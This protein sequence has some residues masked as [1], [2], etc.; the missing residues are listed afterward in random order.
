M[1]FLKINNY[2][3]N[4]S[5]FSEKI[6]FNN[7]NNISKHIKYEKQYINKS[8]TVTNSNTMVFFKNVFS[9]HSSCT[10]IFLKNTSYSG[11][12]LKMLSGLNNV[13]KLFFFNFFKK[14]KFLELKF[15]SYNI[16]FNFSKSN[17]FFFDLNYIFKN[18]I[19]LNESIFS[20][21]IVKL[22]KRLKKKSKSK[23]DFELK[24]LHKNKRYSHTIK[25][26]NLYSNNFNYYKF[27]ERILST[28]FA[29]LFEQKNSDL[30]KKKIYTY[31]NVLK[32]KFMN[33]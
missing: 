20:T 27:D 14:S 29:T 5:V 32:Q 16:F 28:L 10:D 24:Y 12:K 4:N 31:N 13:S 15:P 8:T 9:K 26:L 1:K 21:K 3:H 18:I 6:T 22:D 11:G 7:F 2:N 30:Y 17:E 25:L 23:F 19:T 33:K